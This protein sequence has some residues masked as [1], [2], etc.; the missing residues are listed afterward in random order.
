MHVL[1]KS[2]NINRY[3]I[4]IILERVFGLRDFIPKTVNLS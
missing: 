2:S 4:N 1:G 3:K